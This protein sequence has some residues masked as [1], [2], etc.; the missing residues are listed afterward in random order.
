MLWRNGQIAFDGVDG[1]VTA[2]CLVKD[3]SVG[4]A[5]LILLTPG[6]FPSTFRL[7]VEGIVGQDCSVRWRQ[8][9]AVGVAFDLRLEA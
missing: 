6:D 3:I 4:G 1:P 7:S 5:Q 8:E 9:G 2:K